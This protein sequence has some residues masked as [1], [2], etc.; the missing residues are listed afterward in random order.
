M[1]DFMKMLQQ[2]QEMTGRMQEVQE[3][4]LNE[5]VAGTAG[6]GVVRVETDGKGHLRSIKIDPSVASADDVAMLEDLIVV[7][8][9]D[10]QKRAGELEAR[11]MA[12]LTGGMNLPFPLP[13]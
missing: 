3:R 1:A 4:L 5:T 11:E 9:R 8:V 7:A 12:A 6:G 13:F 10:A 2:A